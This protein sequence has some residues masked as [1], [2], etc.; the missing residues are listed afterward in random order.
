MWAQAATH[1]RI[2]QEHGIISLCRTEVYI[3]YSLLQANIWF[4]LEFPELKN[5]LDF[6]ACPSSSELLKQAAEISMS[7]AN[8]TEQCLRRRTEGKAVEQ[9]F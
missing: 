5:V 9:T 4:M 2:L 8:R 7:C 6:L 1:S 3:S